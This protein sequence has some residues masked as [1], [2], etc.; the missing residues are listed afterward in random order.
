MAVVTGLLIV[1]LVAGVIL[2][3]G[4]GYTVNVR[5]QAATQ[6]V[7]GNLVKIAGRTVGTV[8]EIR[9][10]PNGL[11]ELH[12][13]LDD[14]VAPLR[15]GTRATLRI[16]SLSGIVNRY[17]DL[18][19]PPAGG[20]QI[21]DGGLIDAS[22]TTSA[23]DVD[24]LFNL[25]DKRA[26]DGLRKVLRGSAAQYVGRGAEANAGWKYLSPS[27]F[28]SSRLFQ[29]I[30]GDTPVL[31]RFLSG[32]S[33]LVGDLAERDGDLSKL[34][35]RL[36]TATGAIADEEK[37]L[38]GAIAALPPFM[39]RAN[40]TFVNLRDTLDD[41]DPLVAESKPVAPKLRA[42]L[43]QLAPF[44]TNAV[45]IVK[46][47]ADDVAKPGTD[48]DLIELSKAVLPFRNIAVGPVNVNG[49]E[50]PGSFPTTVDSLAG[51]RKHW[52]FFRNYAVDFTG[53]LDD[54]SH[55]GLYDANGSTSRS[56]LSVN[57]FSAVNGL[58]QPIPP[59]L[60]NTVFDAIATRNQR[61]RCPGSSERPAPD[62]SNPIKV[63]GEGACDPTQLP[64]GP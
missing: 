11:A 51:S 52:A 9:L 53:W 45:P 13:K 37:S 61:N 32:T 36:A 21:P 39:Q 6:V 56:A 49:K 22:Q 63:T 60:R 41:V 5:F 4:D 44:A 3:K 24:Q 26:R 33:R 20:E 12:L 55:S 19:I 43:T 38:S 23:V 27:L 18:Q 54:F 29:E 59:E 25:F 8:D 2:L 30:G 16:A 31:E 15:T 7:K 17:V 34:I 14:D 48:N 64:P 35:D 47:L 40:T 42:V 57:A 28:A 1:A 58:L 10:T 46:T 62:R 50:R